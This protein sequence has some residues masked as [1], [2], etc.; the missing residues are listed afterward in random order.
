MKKKYGSKV[1]LGLLMVFFYLPILYMMVFSFNGSKSLSK[2][3]GFSLRWYEQM[4][5]NKSMIEAIYYT[6]VIAILATIISTVVGTLASIGLSKSK[7]VLKTYVEQINNLPIMNPEI[8]TAIGLM[9]FF[10]T[11][12]IE[13]GFITLLLAHIAFCIPYV[14][15]SVS[16]RLRRLDPNLANAAMDLGA[17]PSY[18]LRKVIIPQ[19][20]PGIVAGALIAFTMSFDDFIISY[21]VSGNGIKNISILVY[22]MSKRINPS[23]NALST[24]IVVIITI[25]LIV[26]NLMSMKKTKT[27]K[28]GQRIGLA[29]VAACVGLTIFGLQKLRSNTGGDFD[30]IETYGCDTLNVFN[31]GEYI[32]EDTIAK[33]EKKYNVHVNYSLFASNEEMY[34]KLLS[35]ESYDV[36]VPSDYMIEQLMQEDRLQ[37]INLD[38]IKN[39]DAL[40]PMVTGL[41]YDPKNEYSIPYF[42]GSVGIMYNKNKVSQ[43]DLETEGFGILQ[44]P[45]Y[46]GR[47]FV[48]DSERD[49]FMMA[50]K[51]LGYSM[52]TSNLDEINEAYEWLRDIRA[53]DP[54][55][56]TDEVIDGMIN[57]EKDIAVV[58]SGDATYIQMENPN[59]AYYEPLEGTNIWSDAMVIPK[60]SACPL[61][62]E[63]YIDFNLD[64]TIA[65][66][67][68]EYIGYT[69]SVQSVIDDLIAGEFKDL[70]SYLPRSGYDKDEIFK[71][72]PKIRK[73]ISEL[74]VKVKA[75]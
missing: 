34:T 65:Y 25:V 14:M 13:K 32:G 62:A 15:L 70:P 50:L 54:V 6:V 74:W 23:I 11:M 71:Y 29:V 1:F 60:N 3:T 45:K 66:E 55:F 69:S 27:N 7:K 16:P 39:Y 56:V 12:K 5:A 41:D 43:E 67:N 4:F 19:L 9:L 49:S 42:W 64:E 8:V 24:I 20:M 22:T 72:N 63:A 18:A 28:T 37:K 26:V 33:F 59:M 68:S 44:N 35:G 46:K 75:K 40:S 58:Y 48:Y 38:H 21:F 36:L 10:T 61:L 17:T 30:P 47:I 51:H 2:F 73:V 31:A 57:G 52:N 53:N